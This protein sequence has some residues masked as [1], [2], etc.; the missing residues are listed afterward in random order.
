MNLSC[1]HSNPLVRE[2]TT[3]V[4]RLL[5]ALVPENVKLHELTTGDWLAFAKDYAALINYYKLTD[6]ESPDDDW[7]RFFPDKIDIDQTLAQDSEGTVEP[8]L[9]LFIAFLKLL[10]YPQKSLNGIPKRHLDFYYREVLQLSP[11]PFSPDTVH[12]IFEL[13]KNANTEL[14]EE[15]SA[16]EAGKDSEGNPRTY[17]M[18]ENLVINQAQVAAIHSLYVDNNEILRYAFQPH[19]E[20]VDGEPIEEDP[21]WSAFGNPEWPAAD[22]EIV[23]TGEIFALKEGI[24]KVTVAWKFSKSLALSGLVQASLTTKKGWTDERNVILDGDRN[25]IWSFEIPE[26][27]DPITAYNTEVHEKRLNTGLPAVKFRFTKAADYAGAQKIDVSGLDVTVDVTGVSDLIINNELGLQLPD[28]PFL[29]FGPRPKRGSAM[30]IESKEF[31]GKELTSFEI[32]LNWLNVPPNFSQHYK[33]YE[34]A[35]A[36]KQT[37]VSQNQGFATLYLTPIIQ[38]YLLQGQKASV[39]QEITTEDP[40]PKRKEF[41]VSVSSGYQ[42]T[43][44]VNEMFTAT[45]QI[46][47][48]ANFSNIK[49][50]KIQLK[51][52]ESFYHE[53]YNGIYVATVAKSGRYF[54]KEDGS[55]QYEQYVLEPDDLPNE[56]YTPLVDAVTLNYSAKA[57]I[58]L[59]STT[60]DNEVDNSLQLIHINPFGSSSINQQS[61]LLPCLSGHRFYLAVSGAEARDSVSML[62]QVS[63][64]SEDPGE[65]SFAQDEGIKWAVLTASDIWQA[66]T[67]DNI[68]RNTTNNFLRSGII[69]FSLPK[70]SATSHYLM[71]DGLI[72]LRAELGFDKPPA[73]VARFMGVHTQAATASFTDNGNALDHLD[74]GLPPEIIKQLVQR[75]SK[76]KSVSQPYSSFGGKNTETDTNFYRRISERL[77]HKDRALTIWDYEH[78]TLQDFPQVHKIKCLNHTRFANNAVDELSPGHVTLVV[79]PKVTSASGAFGLYPS[80]SQNVKDEIKNHLAS[81]HGLHVDL[82]VVNPLYELVKFAFRVSFHKQYDFN[83]YRTVLQQDLIALLA[84]WA[85]DNTTDI[86]FNHEIYEYDI[87][88]FIENLEYVDF[89][90]DFIMYHIPV[91]GVENRQRSIKPSNA[92]A[93][94]A[95]AQIHEIT[96]ALIY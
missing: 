68:I 36:A 70:E 44:S 31:L 35:I 32:G 69:Q 85:Y 20:Y 95:P 7:E 83:F 18:N 23:L 29:P 71:G 15:V 56:P 12:V 77:R 58:D 42:N 75:K 92:M 74:A 61:T 14:V 72:W 81:K 93:V 55:G 86:I 39:I 96:E 51:L 34:D 21:S 63:E 5:D 65:S 94:L 47:R 52:I 43:E 59:T 27:E 38:T 4:Q 91:A 90:E 3:Q 87:I 6:H 76:I 57:S 49:G 50:G 60:I 11:N 8:H 54:L 45:P 80:V 73:A 82:D 22:L 40:D 41:K 37:L 16:L 13:A 19:F 17:G 24:R 30:T 10:E 88:N 33:H 53:L 46:N 26:D 89:V 9:A 64:G 2:G 84:P 78:L 25:N 1:A 79:V 62:F 67:E 28:K 66:L 48:N